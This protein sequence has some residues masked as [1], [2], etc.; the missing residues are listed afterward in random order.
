MS[1]TSES[2]L[3]PV[4]H[5]ISGGIL[6]IATAYGLAESCEF[7]L[8]G[9]AC[10]SVWQRVALC[11]SVLISMA[12]LNPVDSIWMV[13]CVAVCCSVLQC[14][15]ACGSVVQCV[16]VCCSVLQCVAVCCNVWQRVAVCGHVLQCVAVCCS[17]L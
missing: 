8:E 1:L 9:A 15:A 13:Q 7:N 2:C 14:V 4:S 5:V 11:C 12:S 16:A 17:V 10:C 6:A 3:S